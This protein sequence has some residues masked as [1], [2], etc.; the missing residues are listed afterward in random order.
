MKIEYQHSRH[1]KNLLIVPLSFVTKYRRKIFYGEF[2]NDIKQCLFDI[3]QKNLWYVIRMETDKDHVHMLMQY[4]PT[5][6]I[7]K[8]VS[9][10]K[11]MSTY[12]MWIKHP[13]ILLKYYWNTK[14]LWSDGYFAASIGQVSQDTIEKYIEQQG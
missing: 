6:S 11:Q 8:I 10:L 13:D 7:T 12:S 9:K 2:R 4:N 3:C 14:T 5:D 1:N